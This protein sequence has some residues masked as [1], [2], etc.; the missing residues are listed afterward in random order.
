[1]K[2]ITC[3]IELEMPVVDLKTGESSAMKPCELTGFDN[4]FNL[5]ELSLGPVKSL[6]ELDSLIGNK[7]KKLSDHLSHSGLGLINFSE[8]PFVNISPEFYK[9]MC[10]PRPIY[11]YWRNV[12]GWNHISGI[13]AK[14]HMS[15]SFGVS[16][17]RAVDAL[18]IMLG[19]SPAFI[20]IYANSPFE[21]GYLTEN[22]ENRLT[23]W[24][25]MFENSTYPSDKNNGRRS[26]YFSSLREYFEWM[27]GDNYI[28][29]LPRS[30][31]HY[32]TCDDV[33]APVKPVTFNEFFTSSGIDTQSILTGEKKFIEPSVYH[34]EYFQFAQFPDARIRFFLKDNFSH[35]EFMDKLDDFGE[36]TKSVYIEM[37]SPGTNLPDRF[38]RETAGD[39]VADS[40][41]ISVCA[42]MKGL[43]CNMDEA[44]KHLPDDFSSLRLS[45][46][47]ESLANER[48][49]RFVGKMLLIADGGLDE[50]EKWML[51]YPKYVFETGLSNSMRGVKDYKSGKTLQNMVL[52]RLLQL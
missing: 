40:V 46:I 23:L 10:V 38:T 44:L 24:I 43:L 6:G 20:S 41:I 50:S 12:R 25:R 5:P 37:R 36:I 13:D 15:P 34:L 22:L 26:L 32:K 3:G 14:A 2:N 18:N 19:Y 7:L 27:Y 51:A 21:G 17:E 4:G 31:I 47:R 29:A 33:F 45:A 8:H 48:L 16:A 42:L 39:Q 35:T 11:K 49:K 9:K 1:M 28:H 30:Y 52:D